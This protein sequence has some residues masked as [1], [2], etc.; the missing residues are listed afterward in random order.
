MAAS[1]P[2]D[3]G[4]TKV[5]ARRLDS[6]LGRTGAQLHTHSPNDVL[7]QIA[8]PLV[9]ILAIAVR[10]TMSAHSM[11]A[12]QRVNP[13]VMELWR[14]QVILRAEQVLDRWERESGLVLFPDLAPV[15][16]EGGWPADE[17]LAHLFSQAGA[18]NDAE[19]L[20]ERLVAD[21]LQDPFSALADPLRAEADAMTADGEGFLQ[22]QSLA[23]E[24]I[25]QRSRG[26]EEQ[27]RFLQ[28]ELVA[29]VAASVP[30]T[31]ETRAG[32]VRQEMQ[33]L[34]D[35]LATRD[36]PLLDQ[37]RGEFG[38]MVPDGDRQEDQ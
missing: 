10:L 22:M 34:A 33:V 30:V 21:V 5:L 13:V 6:L 3:N 38:T 27:I 17:R 37:V 4:H 29:E 18:L 7:V 1:P 32:D 12:G 8:L 20:R 24:I 28:W 31:V 9:L 11:V 35:A 19:S 15:R 14:Q 36:Y 16:W 25:G 2:R 26:W 23:R